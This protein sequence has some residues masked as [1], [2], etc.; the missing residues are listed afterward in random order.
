MEIHS[1]TGKIKNSCCGFGLIDLS[2]SSALLVGEA[3]YF[4]MQL[5]PDEEDRARWLPFLYKYLL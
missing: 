2:G 4:C 3:G 5:F 1:G